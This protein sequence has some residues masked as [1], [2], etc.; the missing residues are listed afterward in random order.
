MTVD[1][2]KIIHLLGD[3][4]GQV[5][6]EIESPEIFN[7]EESTRSDAKARRGGDHGAAARLQGSIASMPIEHARPVASA[8]TVYF[9]LVNLAEELV[10]TNLLIER[11][12]EAYPQPYDESIG[13]A[14]AA[15]KQ[16]G[17]TS[18]DMARLLES[19][20]VELVL[21]AHPTEARRRTIHSNSRRIGRLLEQ[22][23]D[24]RL[25]LA[26]RERILAALHAQI[27]LLWMTDRARTAKPAVTDEVRTGLYFI[28][29]TLWEVVPRLYEDLD[30]A[31]SEHFP[32]LQC[33]RSWLRL[34]SWIGGDRDGNPFVT[35]EVTAE[36]LRLHRGLAVEKHRV[37]LQELARHLSISIHRMPMP[38][39]L[40]A[41]IDSRRPLPEHVSYIEKR[42]ATEPYRLIFSLLAADLAEA[43]REDMTGRLLS[44]KPH[45]AFVQLDR[46]MEPVRI[47]AS[48]LPA[49]L[50]KDEIRLLENQLRAF[51]LAAARM[52]IREDTAGWNSALGE[53]LRAL[54]IAPEFDSLS[55]ANR[56]ELYL[57][58]LGD[59][60]P[61]LSPHPGI[62][63][64][65]A[66][67]WSLLRLMARVRSVYGEEPIGAVILSMTHSAADVLAVLLM[68]RWV[69]C[70]SR[71]PIVP[72]FETIEDL[73]SAPDILDKLFS[74]DMYRAHL[75][76]CNNEQ[77]VMIGYSDSNKDG[78][79]LMANW[80]L[81]RAQEAIAR[82]AEKYR[83]PLT[84]FHGR[85]GTIARG[86]GPAN[87]AIRAQPPGS[88]RGKFR[89]TEQGEIIASRYSNKDLAHRH[90]E[91]IVHAVLLASA[92]ESG[93]AKEVPGVWRDALQ[94]ASV[95][96]RRVYRAL[97]YET[98][99]FIEFWQAV[100]P[101]DEIKR[102]TIG[103]R[104]ATRSHVGEVN[105]I[106]AIPWVFS[107]MQSRFNLAGWYSLGSG[108]AAVAD[109]KLLREM[110]AAWP[111]FNTL[112]EN[113][114]MSLLKA[115]MDIAALYVPLVPDRASARKIFS[116][117]RDEFRLSCETV[118]T[119]SGHSRLLEADPVAQN[120][121]HLRNPYLDPLN[122]LQVEMLRRLR[123][124]S[125]SEGAE[126]EALREV[127]VLTI[128]GIAAG[129]RS[130]G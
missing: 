111:F 20:S 91:Q 7:V 87:H 59:T 45:R 54:E 67:T 3:M 86:G 39:A 5:I 2:S 113:A 10:D 8:F 76:T 103:S 92:P 24:K 63:P 119:I 127:V 116:R 79:Y 81:Y 38:G 83:I 73:E 66:E 1:I 48:H 68:L 31:L 129:L 18:S 118:L 80:A 27:V 9:D 47:I 89:L 75:E 58:M 44:S 42:Y 125:D 90:L 77:I 105:Q 52:D 94:R 114:E 102:M 28:D 115:D 104:P 124:L 22:S 128:N 84:I 34:A 99:G 82:V 95:A 93:D 74:S 101:L 26:Q 46:L 57:N 15:L 23:Q 117:I 32:E 13:A 100:T 17:V 51:G 65:S 16:R 121:V 109:K 33:D 78:G 4:L 14:V 108:L 25:P 12:N 72:L 30:N 88:I 122:Y 110:Y 98:P 37:A 55:D 43:S 11:A 61:E 35:A 123:S 49:R 70:D 71:Q 53:V 36:A 60:L 64:A 97:V 69:G 107:W 96:A 40:K 85:G 106:R 126:A 56:L 41:W 29:T 50:A 6:S 130:T 120:A 21:T 19:L 112:L 62:T